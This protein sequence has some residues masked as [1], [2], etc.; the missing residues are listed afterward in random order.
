[1]AHNPDLSS[2]L[3]DYWQAA[4]ALLEAQIALSAHKAIAPPANDPHLMTPVHQRIWH[5]AQRDTFSHAYDMTA[6]PPLPK[7]HSMAVWL[8]GI[9]ILQ[10]K[11]LTL[12]QAFTQNDHSLAHFP[13]VNDDARINIRARKAAIEQAISIMNPPDERAPW[14][15]DHEIEARIKDMRI[16]IENV[17]SPASEPARGLMAFMN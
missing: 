9:D 16:I 1:M 12:E 17:P 2:L 13:L 15:D 5:S 7:D 6:M 11:L 8:E 3:L 10:K 14:F 4:T